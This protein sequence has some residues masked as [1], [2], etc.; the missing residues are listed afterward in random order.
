MTLVP[1]LFS[2]ILVINGNG[3]EEKTN[4]PG[5]LLQDQCKVLMESIAGTYEGD[6]KKGL[7]H[8]YG[9]AVG[10]DTYEGGFKKGLPHGKGIYSWSN[11]DVYNG[12]WSK[13]KMDGKG[14]LLKFRDK[15]NDLMI[16]GYWLEGEY[17]GISKYPYKVISKSLTVQQVRFDRINA[18]KKTIEFKFTRRGKPITVSGFSLAGSFGTIESQSDYFVK[19]RVH[20]YPF[21]GGIQFD[22]PD[23]IQTIS[24][25]GGVIQG[26]LEFEIYQKGHW[27]VTIEMSSME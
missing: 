17:V 8:G 16:S 19:I 12:E 26:R 14:E 10:P 15:E 24:S 22:V 20:E 27:V 1:F 9:K 25:P 4:I 7:A 18:E 5:K 13:G 11:G 6:C 23:P 3:I 21:T 2:I